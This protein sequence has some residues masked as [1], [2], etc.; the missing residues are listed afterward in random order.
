MEAP[1]SSAP[2]ELR[3]VER[4]SILVV[5][6][7]EDAAEMLARVLISQ[8]HHVVTAHD[9]IEALQ[10][11]G[12]HNFDAALLDIGLPVIDGYE[13]ARR[14]RTLRSFANTR[15]IAVTGYGQESD[16][17]RSAAAGFDE[18]LVKPVT[19]DQLSAIIAGIR[20]HA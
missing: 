16:R 5:D 19:M 8:G 11:V 3:G 17:K 20:Q 18:H 13:L 12:A 7:N 9:G 6:D 1:A 4:L 14:L 2:P 10:L 15:L